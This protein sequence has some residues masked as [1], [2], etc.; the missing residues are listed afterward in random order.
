MSNV[1]EQA[2]QELNVEGCDRKL[3]LVKVPVFVAERWSHT[4][5]RD[6]RGK[7]MRRENGDVLGTMKIVGKDAN[8]KTIITLDDGIEMTMEDLGAN[9]NMLVFNNDSDGGFSVAGKITKHM[10]LQPKDNEQYRTLI[11]NRKVKASKKANVAAVDESINSVLAEDAVMDFI[12]PVYTENKRKSQELK[13]TR[14]AQKITAPADNSLLVTAILGAFNSSEKLTAKELFAFVY[15][16]YPQVSDLYHEKEIRDELAK[17]ATYATG[18]VYKHYWTLKPDYRDHTGGL[19]AGGS[20][21]LEDKMG[22]P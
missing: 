12:P 5:Q 15:A 7:R 1:G 14:K 17:Y 16:T 2:R 19:G 11:R 6:E 18:G 8:K 3:W 9:P 10:A 22:S 21:T 13:Q 4:E 20:N